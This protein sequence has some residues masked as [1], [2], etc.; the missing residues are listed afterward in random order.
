M[1]DY[2]MLM[3]GKAEREVLD[4]HRVC[5]EVGKKSRLRE[6]Y[7]KAHDIRKFEIGLYWKRALYFWGFETAIVAAYGSALKFESGVDVSVLFFLNILGVVFSV[8]WW[9]TL[10]GSKQWQENW[11]LHIDMLESHISGNLYKVVLFYEGRREL[12][13]SVSRINIA[14]SVMFIVSWLIV[15]CN[16][17]WSSFDKFFLLLVHV[18]LGVVIYRLIPPWFATNLKGDCGRLSGRAD[19]SFVARH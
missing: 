12:F 9:L 5:E 8:F 7:E 15:S 2:W 14:F 18:A 17:W 10:R 16:M 3:F 4:E 13:A 19:L 11:E 1:K 6:A